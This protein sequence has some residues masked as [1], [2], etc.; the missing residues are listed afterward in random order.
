MSAIVLYDPVD[1]LVPNRVTA[2]YPSAHTPD[3]DGVTDKLVDPDL[4]SLV[5][6]PVKFWKRDGGDVVEMTTQEQEDLDSLCLR[7]YGLMEGSQVGCTPP[8]DFDFGLLNMEKEK[9]QTAGSHGDISQMNYYDSF[10]PATGYGNLVVRRDFSFQYISVPIF[11]IIVTETITWFRNDGTA[12]PTT[13][14]ITRTYA[15]QRWT[16]WLVSKRDQIIDWCKH[17]AMTAMFVTAPSG[18]LPADP[19][20]IMATGASWFT[21]HENAVS[22]YLATYDTTLV[23]DVN[24]DSTAWL[25][26][27]IPDGVVPGLASGKTIRELITDELVY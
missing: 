12:H 13:K 26:N 2:Y 14:V 5:G 11:H 7:V 1:P 20:A 18:G 19:G 4:S 17:W 10:D 3:Y 22:G 9:V 15:G 16:R 6:V 8:L 25:D 23:A 27:V 24:A 21:S